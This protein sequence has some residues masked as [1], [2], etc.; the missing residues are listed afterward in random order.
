MDVQERARL[1]RR[2]VRLRA[3]IKTTLIT[4]ELVVSRALPNE[5]LGEP[6]SPP[7]NLSLLL[8]GQAF[9]R[10]AGEVLIK[11]L[12]GSRGDLALLGHRGLIGNRDPGIL[13]GPQ[14]KGELCNLLALVIV[15][16][17]QRP[18]WVRE[19]AY[20]RLLAKY[21]IRV[22]LRRNRIALDNRERD[23]PAIALAFCRPHIL[24]VGELVLAEYLDERTGGWPQAMNGN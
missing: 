23:G 12:E 17:P 9:H 4:N 3:W 20:H 16:R 1:H 2:T 5:A 8:L 13:G 7:P 15:Q 21:L 14:L 6:C 22:R 10:R 18:R 19:E 24:H 11:E